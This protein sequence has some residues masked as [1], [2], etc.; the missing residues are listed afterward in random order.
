MRRGLMARVGRASGRWLGGFMSAIS[1]VWASVLHR[2]ALGRPIVN[3]DGYRDRLLAGSDGVTLTA[4]D[5]T[6]GEV[7]WTAP[8]LAI[9]FDADALVTGKALEPY[10]D[11]WIFSSDRRMIGLAPL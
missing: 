8:F 1:R 10:G 2:C 5:V 3:P 11:G 9:D 7:A 4:V 6:T